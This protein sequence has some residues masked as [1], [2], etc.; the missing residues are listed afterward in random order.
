MRVGCLSVD[1]S[2]V[3]RRFFRIHPL[4]SSHCSKIFRYIFQTHRP[5]GDGSSASGASGR[6]WR[7][8]GYKRG[9]AEKTGSHLRFFFRSYPVCWQKALATVGQS[10]VLNLEARKPRNPVILL[11]FMASESSASAFV[12]QPDRRGYFLFLLRA[13]APLRFKIPCLSHCTEP[14]GTPSVTFFPAFMRLC[15]GRG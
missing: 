12:S 7:L 5:R 15:R 8:P 13:S 4:P 6:A 9:D 3:S 1:V 2:K 10:R 11:G 14:F